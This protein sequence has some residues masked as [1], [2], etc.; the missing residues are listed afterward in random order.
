M[1]IWRER[2]LKKKTVGCL[3]LSN[4][5]GGAFLISK[6]WHFKSWFLHIFSM[7]GEEERLIRRQIEIQ[8]IGIAINSFLTMTIAFFGYVT[9]ISNFP[10]LAI[11]GAVLLTFYGCVLMLLLSKLWKS[12][13][14]WWQE[15]NIENTFIPL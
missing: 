10:Q 9:A 2:W 7:K 6:L 3:F 1:I 8:E 4:P 5:A 11:I 15:V 12:N 14:N 13:K